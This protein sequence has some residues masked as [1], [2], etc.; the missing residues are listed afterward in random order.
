MTVNTVRHHE[1][2]RWV[3]EVT[4][5]T[6]PDEV[7]WI[8]G[9]E[10]QRDELTRMLVGRGVL[11]PLDGRF[12]G[13]FYAR[14][15]PRDVARVVKDTHICSDQDSG[16]LTNWWDP[17]EARF[18]MENR[19]ADAM[20]GRTMYVVPFSMGPLGSTLSK[21]V[22]QVTDSPYVVLN[23]LIMARVGQGAL[24]ELGTDGEF[25]RAIHSVG[26]PLA[27]GETDVLW[28]CNPDKLKVCHFPDTMEVWSYGSGYGGNALLGK[29]CVALRLASAQAAND[30]NGAMAEHMMIIRITETA[31]SRNWHVAAAFPS[32]CGKT[33]LAMLQPTIPGYK[34]TTIGDDIN[35]MRLG[36]DERLYA[37]NP[38]AGFFGVAPGTGVATNPV[39]IA[40]ILKGS[41]LTNVAYNPDTGEAW[42]PGLE[43]APDRLITW[44]GE[45]WTKASGVDSETTAHPNSRFTTPYASCG[46]GDV[47]VWN[48]PAGVPIDLIL[49]GGR[50][51]TTIPLVRL[52]QDWTEGVLFGAM[53]SSATT[54]AAE[55]KVGVVAH[56]PF[57][58]APFFGLSVVDYIG[59]WLR[60]GDLVSSQHGAGRL[61]RIGF[62]NWF[63]RDVNDGHF[64]WPGFGNNARV[65]DVLLRHLRGETT[66][67]NTPIGLLPQSHDFNLEGITVSPRDMEVLTTVDVEAWVAELEEIAAYFGTFDN[68]PPALL[69]RL[70]RMRQDLL[71]W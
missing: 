20:Q 69:E 4:Q 24:D 19:F 59:N 42:W 2:Q 11:T 50:R 43:P 51:P 25:V 53:I 15:D 30:P 52:A 29:K 36:N 12:A 18:E 9:S 44:K 49:F 63:R 1:L 34:V 23:T 45:L 8:D 58:M 64:L 60:I 41:L 71:D 28:P 3:D 38:E 62:V 14:S 13:S 61:P 54:A 67:V 40:A 32:S 6:R 22:V 66:L 10:T 70:A 37:I 56:D 5:L 35:W 26:V 46:T 39:A 68:F 16:P 55:G 27:P 31:T 65:I 47:E 57:A 17:A 7:V 33:N 21:L 48:D